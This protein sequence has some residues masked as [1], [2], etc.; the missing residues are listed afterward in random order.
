MWKRRYKQFKKYKQSTKRNNLKKNTKIK[1]ILSKEKPIYLILDNAQIHHTK[2]IDE[3][4]E[5]LNI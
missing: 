5:I 4:Y 1:E 3:V 2:I